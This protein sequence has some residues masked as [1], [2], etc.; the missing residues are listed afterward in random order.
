MIMF[1]N[2]NYF[3]RDVV[4]ESEREDESTILFWGGWLVGWWGE[5]DGIDEMKMTTG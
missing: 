4:V 5:L 2:R 1:Y 3:H